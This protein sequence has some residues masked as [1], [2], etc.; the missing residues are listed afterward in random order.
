M[1]KNTLNKPGVEI[2]PFLAS[3]PDDFTI[4]S[5]CV[6]RLYGVTCEC[7]DKTFDEWADELN[8]GTHY[9]RPQVWTKAGVLKL[10]YFLRCPRGVEVRTFVA[11][12]IL[13]KA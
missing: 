8:E 4:T 11:E 3:I 10:G 12:E 2:V 7:V 5:D 9:L 6:G 13:K 1:K